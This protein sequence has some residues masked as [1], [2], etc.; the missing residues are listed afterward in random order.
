MY[1]I[2][3]EQ[4]NNFWSYFVL[5]SPLEMSCYLAMPKIFA[6]V[7]GLFNDEKAKKNAEILAHVI[8]NNHPSEKGEYNKAIWIMSM[9][10]SYAHYL[11]ACH[12]NDRFLNPGS[13][14]LLCTRIA[15][16]VE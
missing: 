4:A 12:N 5:E 8:N 7:E 1:T 14:F 2:T 15:K 10:R 9:A 3:K 13:F 16:G 11:E 6:N